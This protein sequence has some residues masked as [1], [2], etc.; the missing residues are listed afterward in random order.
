[1]RVSILTPKA[2]SIRRAIL[3]ESAAL[4]FKRLDKAGREICKAGAGAVKERAGGSMIFVGMKTPGGG[5][6]FSWKGESPS[7]RIGVLLNVSGKFSGQGGAGETPEP[8]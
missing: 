6:V 8:A 4:P 3:P 7:L 2:F 1:M 5:A